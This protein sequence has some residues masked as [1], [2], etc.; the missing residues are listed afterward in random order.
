MEQWE[1]LQ[2]YCLK[3]L[4]TTSTSKTSNTEHTYEHT[5]KEHIYG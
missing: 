3:F 4:P 5:N 2:E 1:N